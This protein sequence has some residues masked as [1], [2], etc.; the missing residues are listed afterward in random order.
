MN[1]TNDTA[2]KRRRNSRNWK[3]DLLVALAKTGI[4]KAAC[5][6]ANVDRM[7]VHRHRQ[8]DPEF[9]DSFNEALDIAVESLEIEARRRAHDGVD[10][11][12]F[13]QGEQCGS[14]RE[15]SDTLLIFTLKAL[16]PDKYRE[17]RG[18][19]N[20]NIENESQAANPEVAAAAFAAAT[21][22]TLELKGRET[23]PMVPRPL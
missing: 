23:V 13:Y 6:E 10:R 16:R 5:E 8:S 3:P 15:Y 4:I 21:A 22:K 12:V 20:V 11:P 19:I 9:S 1:V 14:V 18:E 17:P 7:T 2:T